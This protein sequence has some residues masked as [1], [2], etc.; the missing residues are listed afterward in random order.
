M[1]N[2]N[3]SGER[4]T[5]A[6]CPALDSYHA[7]NVGRLFHAPAQPEFSNPDAAHKAH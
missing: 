6:R 7:A 1:T 4:H 3:G 2:D 5:R